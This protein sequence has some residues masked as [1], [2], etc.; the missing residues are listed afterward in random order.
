MEFL[1]SHGL[2]GL[3]AFAIALIWS[4]LDLLLKAQ[5]NQES[6]TGLSII[7]IIILFTFGD[8]IESFAYLYWPGLIILGICFKSKHSRST[9][10]GLKV[11]RVLGENVL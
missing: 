2:V 4:F 9:L 11:P 1:Y 5:T 3:C 10:T 6:K 8:N 7:L